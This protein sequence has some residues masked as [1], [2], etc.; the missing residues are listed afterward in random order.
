MIH[1]TLQQSHMICIHSDLIVIL[2]MHGLAESVRVPSDT[3]WTIHVNKAAQDFDL[4]PWHGLMKEWQKSEAYMMCPHNRYAA[5]TIL[6]KS[7]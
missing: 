2:H 3:N 4:H 7:I 5:M 1:K 6:Y